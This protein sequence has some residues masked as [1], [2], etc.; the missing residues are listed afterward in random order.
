MATATKTPEKKPKAKKVYTTEDYLKGVPE[1]WQEKI[2][3]EF[4]PTEKIEISI[5][6]GTRESF[7]KE[8]YEARQTLYPLKDGVPDIS[9]GTVVIN[10]SLFTPAEIERAKVIASIE[11]RFGNRTVIVKS[12]GTFSTG[13][14]ENRKFSDYVVKTLIVGHVESVPVPS[15]SQYFH[16]CNC[17]FCD[18]VGFYKERAR[19]GWN[20]TGYYEHM[21]GYELFVKYAI[22]KPLILERLEEMTRN[23]SVPDKVS[24]DD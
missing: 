1:D 10:G 3:K 9:N 2:R 11:F 15:G 8:Q 6:N 16:N 23:A 20:S 19:S 22:I 24:K 14:Q 17:K 13:C 5:G 12:D 4:K 7:T 21:E 18:R